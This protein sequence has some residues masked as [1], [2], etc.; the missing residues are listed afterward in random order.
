MRRLLLLSAAVAALT[1][2]LHAQDTAR[3]MRKRTMYEDLQLFSQVLNQLRVNHPDSLESH[4]LI[5][6]AIRLDTQQRIPEVQLHRALLLAE[7]RRH[8]LQVVLAC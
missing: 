6:A 1:P 5:M 7:R 2:A 4:D 3:V 8:E